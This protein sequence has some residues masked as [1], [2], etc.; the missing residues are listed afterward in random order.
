[1]GKLILIGL[2]VVLFIL[3]L[4]IL[5]YLKVLPLGRNIT[6][7]APVTTP[8]S[9]QPVASGSN[10]IYANTKSYPTPLPTLQPGSI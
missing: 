4:V 3:L 5:T 10:N 6:S 1:M 2:G 7:T 9:S 8:Q